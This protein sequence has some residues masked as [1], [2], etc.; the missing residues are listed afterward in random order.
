MQVPRISRSVAP[1]LQKSCMKPERPTTTTCHRVSFRDQECHK[2]LE[3]VFV[4]ESYKDYLFLM[5]VLEPALYNNLFD[6]ALCKSTKVAAAV[7]SWVRSSNGRK[8]R[9][10]A[11]RNEKAPPMKPVGKR[12]ENG[13]WVKPHP[14]PFMNLF[15]ML[16][17]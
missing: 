2:S 7:G 4:V 10:D 17:V 13:R 16:N 8:L 6:S 9:M 1:L 14:M 11:Y 15:S 5:R 12:S 3:D